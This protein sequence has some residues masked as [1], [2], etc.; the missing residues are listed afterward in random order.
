MPQSTKIATCSYCGSRAA[1]VFRGEGR[2][3][4][5][6]ASCGAP[7]RDMKPLVVA[8]PSSKPAKQ[9]QKKDKARRK[10]HK[11]GKYRKRSLRDVILKE[12]FDVIGD[13]LD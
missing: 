12:A 11:R 7:L 3:E 4:L 2:Q 8:Q 9:M 10:S 6:C 1:L 5:S 13:I